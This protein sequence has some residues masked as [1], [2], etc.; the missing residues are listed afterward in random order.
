MLQIGYFST[1][2]DAQDAT[3]V[4]EILLR[5]RKANRRDLITGLLVAGGGRYLQVIEGPP[6]SVEALY[7]RI[8]VDPRHVAVASFLTRQIAARTFGSWSMAY[9]RQT[10]AGELNS[11]VDVLTELT[12]EIPDTSLKQQIRYFAGTMMT[13]GPIAA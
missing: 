13:A 12:R 2:T 1:A 10:A 8:L 4:H 3:A 5:A 9:R 7:D 11:F 6:A